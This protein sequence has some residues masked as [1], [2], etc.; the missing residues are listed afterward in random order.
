ME[1]LPVHNASMP[2]QLSLFH[3]NR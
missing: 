1:R 3:R 2:C